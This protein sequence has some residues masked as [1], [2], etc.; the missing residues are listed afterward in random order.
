MKIDIWF[1]LL[2]KYPGPVTGTNG[3]GG[4]G[5][6]GIFTPSETRSSIPSKAFRVQKVLIDVDI[7]N[8]QSA[9]GSIHSHL[10]ALQQTV[11]NND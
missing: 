1:L 2:C 4:C 11:N 10:P 6:G 5:R 8:S 3:T 7:N 9:S